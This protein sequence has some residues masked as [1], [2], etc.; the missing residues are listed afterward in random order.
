MAKRFDQGFGWDSVGEMPLKYWLTRRLFISKCF[1]HLAL[2]I[3]VR[4]SR[5]LS[6][7]SKSDEEG[8]GDERVSCLLDGMG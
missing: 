4:L 6:K 5:A 7:S 3:G 8:G 2:L 1:R